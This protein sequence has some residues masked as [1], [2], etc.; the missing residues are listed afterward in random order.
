MTRPAS[1]S[2][3]F[4]RL[5]PWTRQ[6]GEGA[7]PYTAF[8]M[9]RDQ[10]PMERSVRRLGET[11]GRNRTI[12]GR[13]SSQWNWVARVAAWDAEQNR[14]LQAANVEARLALAKRLAAS[15]ALMQLRGLGKVR[16]YIDRFDRDGQP[17]ELRQGQHF[18]DEL[19]ITEAVRLIDVG[20]RLEGIGRGLPGLDGPA[21]PAPETFVANPIM[22]ALAEDA[23]RL[24]EVVEATRH[25]AALLNLETRDEREPFAIPMEIEDESETKV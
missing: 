23:S 11:I 21:A 19:S 17:A 16:A 18:T 7:K 1:P 12:V 14:L 20:A 15:G 22:E 9:Y 4:D 8:Q 25:L 10:P 24:P 3:Q 2:S 5:E 6:P 13:W